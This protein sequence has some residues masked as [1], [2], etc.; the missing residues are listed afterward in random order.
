MITAIWFVMRTSVPWRDLPAQFGP[1]SSVYT[2][3]RHWSQAGLWARMQALL[4]PHACG[5][6]RSVDCSHVKTHAAGANPAGG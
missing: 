5:D 3:F 4:A 1:W 6:I 2:R